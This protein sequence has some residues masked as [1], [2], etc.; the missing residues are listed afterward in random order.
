ML[1]ADINIGVVYLLAL[2][3]IVV[4][5]IMLA[6]WSSN[7]KWSLLGSLRSAA[8]IVSY[9]IPLGMSL[10]IPVIIGAILIF[11]E[12]NQFQ[13]GGIHNWLVFYALPFTVPAFVIYFI[14]AF[15][16]S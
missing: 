13:S 6:G 3:S 15:G 9:E 16:R 5:G 1:L 8:Q 14:S 7:N 12:I 11:K 4:I 2:S 10:L